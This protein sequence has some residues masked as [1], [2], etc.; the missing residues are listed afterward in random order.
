VA[1]R[2]RPERRAEA[3]A[4]AYRLVMVMALACFAGVVA[5][6]WGLQPMPREGPPA[7]PREI[8]LVL[9]DARLRG[10]QPLP[11]RPADSPPDRRGAEPR[12]SP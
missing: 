3:R 2:R 6:R 4:A 12:P 5:W 10:L 8:P 7:Q 9:R 11:G 1:G